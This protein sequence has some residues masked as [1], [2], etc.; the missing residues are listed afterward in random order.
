MDTFAEDVRSG[1]YVSVDPEAFKTLTDINTRTCG[2][3]FKLNP[4]DLA[5]I[6]EN[7]QHILEIRP[8]KRGSHGNGCHGD[9]SIHWFNFCKEQ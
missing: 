1:K 4:D 3:L 9:W 2:A 8:W 6:S 5:K 7:K